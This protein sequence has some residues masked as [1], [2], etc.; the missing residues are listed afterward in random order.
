MLATPNSLGRAPTLKASNVSKTHGLNT[1]G[2]CWLLTVCLL[3]AAFS[4]N[5]FAE[6][7]S[8]AIVTEET[9]ADFARRAQTIYEDAKAHYHSS[10]ND[11]EAAWQF[12]RASYDWADYAKSKRQRAEIAQ[13]GIAATQKV[14]DHQPDLAQGH[15]YLAMNL[16]QLAQ[17]KE[18]G[19]LR[20]VSR[21]E[22]E[23]K[24]ALS[25]NPDLDYAGPDRNLGLLY[26]EAP[27]WPASV[28]SK[29]KAKLHLTAA[30]KRAPQYPENLLNLIEAYLSWGDRSGA[31][32][33]LKVL[34]QNWDDARKQ[35]TGEQWNSSWVDWKKRRE[36]DARKANDLPRNTSPHEKP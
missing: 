15:Y 34:D 18:L 25:L 26:H 3:N 16:G 29:S 17:T 6:T 1:I 35:F 22:G 33:E 2:V 32:R 9:T 8:A 11:L 5:C 19:A 20:L 12:G 23:F 14:V 28:G 10:P 30:A 21:M 31:L 13:E 36:V 24:T 27:G 4:K 7:N